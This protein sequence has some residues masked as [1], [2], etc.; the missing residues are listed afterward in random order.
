MGE[1]TTV[2]LDIAKSVFQVLGTDADGRVLV[3]RKLTRAGAAF[4]RVGLVGVLDARDAAHGPRRHRWCFRWLGGL[5]HALRASSA[6]SMP[7]H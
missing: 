2:G 7:L 5:H 4:L 3:Q 6:W 1:I